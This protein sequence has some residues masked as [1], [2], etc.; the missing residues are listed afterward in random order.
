MM[1]PFLY[2]YKYDDV[3]DYITRTMTLKCFSVVVHK[4]YRAETVLE[5]HTSSKLSPYH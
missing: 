3:T 5:K 1:Q 4:L 2:I